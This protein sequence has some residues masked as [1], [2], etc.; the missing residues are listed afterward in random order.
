MSFLLLVTGPPGAGKS[1]VARALADK[2]DPSVLVEGDAF[3]AFLARGA[4]EPWLPASRRQNE[5]VVRAAAA[6]TGRFASGGYATV[7]DGVLGPWFLPDFAAQAGVG[8]LH[9]VILLPQAERCVRQVATRAGHGFADEAATRQM[10]GEFARS[11]IDQRHVI[12][13]PGTTP[14]DVTAE[15]LARFRAGSL[16]YR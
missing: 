3:F 4:I 12:T 8:E 16:R 9:Y 7:Y 10:H 6:A 1:T 13:D 14:E 2:F 5:I 11:A 15:V